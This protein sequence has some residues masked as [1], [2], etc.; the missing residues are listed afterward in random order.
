MIQDEKLKEFVMR[1]SGV[2][3]PTERP[4]QQGKGKGTATIAAPGARDEPASSSMNIVKTIMGGPE[5]GDSHN[6]QK[7]YLRAVSNEKIA[8]SINLTYVPPPSVPFE[9]IYFNELEA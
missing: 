8:Q 1:T 6:Q 2:T 4:P 7:K 3:I 5:Y 9:S